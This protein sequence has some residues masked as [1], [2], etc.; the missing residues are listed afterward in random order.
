M[1]SAEVV[2]PPSLGAPVQVQRP[3][4][5]PVD[6]EPLLERNP[7]DSA[8]GSLIGGPPPVATSQPSGPPPITPEDPKCKFG[9]VTTI[10]ATGDAYAFA[11]IELKGGDSHLR[12]IGD[13]VADGHAIAAIG[14]EAVWL[15]SDSATCRMRLGDPIVKKRKPRRRARK[16]RK[17]KK[18]VSRQAPRLP[19]RIADKITRVSATEYRVERAALDEVLEKQ[20][21][22]MRRT[23]ITPIKRGGEMAGVRVGRVSSGSLLHTLGVRNGDVLKSIN[24]YDM[25]SPQKALEAYGRLQTAD[26]LTL[27]LSRRGKPVSIDY[28]IQ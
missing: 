12:R 18:R 10:V 24:G 17:R 25:T 6:A 7:F 22:L 8:T 2:A 9:H 20:A 3:R 11:A 16:K 19:K 13:A 21:Q 28:V 5:P 4:E 23:R 26:R 14:R 27:S 1:V 15:R